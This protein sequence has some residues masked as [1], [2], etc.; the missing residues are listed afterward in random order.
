MNP[1][2]HRL[3]RQAKRGGPPEAPAQHR[4]SV[5]TARLFVSDAS[6]PLA[7]PR[8]YRALAGRAGGVDIRV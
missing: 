6:L 2:A 8:D 5:E 1:A 7:T 3:K 4:A